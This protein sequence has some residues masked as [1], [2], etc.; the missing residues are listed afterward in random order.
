MSNRTTT[1]P[2]ERKAAA[3]G[4]QHDWFILRSLVSKDFKLKYRR[5]I[6]GVAW[7]VL[8][9]LL[10]MV[11]L[12]AVFSYMFRFQIEN[13][14]LYLILGTILFSM[15]SNST[16]D[17][18]RSIIESSALIKKVRINKIVFPLEKV[19]FEMLNF[20][21]SLVAVALVMIFFRVAP[22]LNLLLLPVLLVFMVVFCTGLG[23]MLSSLA[24][25]FRDTVHLWSVV[26]TA[27]M[28]ATPIFYPFDML[29]D[30]MQTAMQFNPMY[31]YVTYFRDIVMWNITPDLMQH[32][33]CLG[34]AVVQFVIGLV[35][36][37]KTEHKFILFV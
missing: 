7:S 32:A 36:F 4:L 31:H 22:T 24:V 5:S 2:R 26:T 21:I 27:W 10:M 34:F 25:F 28:Y 33:L 1:T 15:M 29:P 3:Q 8:N 12:T 14:P 37:R 6:L 16:T 17:A 19:L 13:Y 20:A 9:P 11:V 35:V 23:M 30:W 18:M